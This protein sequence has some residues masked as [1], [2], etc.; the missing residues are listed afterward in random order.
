MINER[1]EDHSLRK[2]AKLTARR[3][4]GQA[5]VEMVIAIG[6][7]GLFV[8]MLSAMLSQTL[9]LSS[10]S[11]NELIAAHAAEELLE[12]ARTIPYKQYEMSIPLNQPIVFLMNLDGSPFSTSLRSNMPVQL[13]LM[14]STTVYGEVNP[15]AALLVNPATKWV[16]GFGNYFPGTATETVSSGTFPSS[17]G[18]IPYYEIKVQITY[19]SGTGASTRTL[20]R[21]AYIVNQGLSLQ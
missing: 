13:D 11:Q 18:S 6:L 1:S 17:S 4:D 3:W 5:L 15:S 16:P 20:T 21:Y 14:N 2:N 8:L 7:S 10:T 19:P 9:L 12:N